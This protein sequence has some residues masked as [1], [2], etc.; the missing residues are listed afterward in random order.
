M[1]K[2]TKSL[3]CV[4]SV[5]LVVF[6]IVFTTVWNAGLDISKWKEQSFISN[7]L[8]NCAISLFGIIAGLGIADNHYRN[9]E[10][11][12]FLLSYSGFLKE[13]EKIE[14]YLDK[15]PYWIRNLHKKESQEKCI[16]FLKDEKGITQAKLILKHLDRNDVK[17]LDRPFQKELPSG[18]KLYFKALSL[19]QINAIIL[20]LDGKIKVKFVHDS[21]FLNAYS[22]NDT[23]SM[24]EQ[25]SMEDKIKNR[26]SIFLIISKIFFTIA[27]G[28]IF[29]GLTVDTANGAKIGE[30]LINMLSRFSILASALYSGF[31]IAHIMVKY[32]CIFIDYKKT[33]LETF[34]LE[35][36]ENHTVKCLTE[37]EEAEEEYKEFEEKNNEEIICN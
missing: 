29:A 14:K 16:R 33:T 36:I 26:K 1:K 30:I 11:G 15:F 2:N 32:D 4:L 27:L 23:K 3:L 25:A 20:V 12:M 19:D 5:L 37:E 10:N 6:L 34:Y 8:I 24:Y 22:K 17:N 18:K 35:V 13:R 31:S 28:M 9:K 21:Y 7:L